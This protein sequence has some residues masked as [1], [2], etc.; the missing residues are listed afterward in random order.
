MIINSGILEGKSIGSGDIGILFNLAMITQV[1]ELDFERHMEMNFLEFLE[2]ICRVGYK[3][4]EFPEKYISTRLKVQL[5]CSNQNLEIERKYSSSSMSPKKS[6]INNGKKQS[7]NNIPSQNGSTNIIKQ[8]TA[9]LSIQIDDEENKNAE[10]K[11]TE[12]SL[13]FVSISTLTLANRISLLV[14]LLIR[15]SMSEFKKAK[16]KSKFGNNQS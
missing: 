3:I 4:Q 12:R 13:R 7:N 8:S 5:N 16:Q 6:G 11:K 14:K 9:N 10:I 15:C 2:A 1:R